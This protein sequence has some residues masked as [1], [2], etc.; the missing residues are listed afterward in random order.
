MTMRALITGGSRGLGRAMGVALARRGA[1]VAFT[2]A[3]RTADADAAR[4]AIAAAG[5]EPLVFQGSVADAAHAAATV[6]A[7]V[8]A[9]GGVDVLIHNAGVNQIL[10]VA[11]IEEQDWDTV[12]DVNVKG[13]FLFARACLKPMIRARRGAILFI[14]SFAS[15]R[16]V[17]SPVHYAAAKSALRGLT[18]ALA[19]EMGKYRIQV[20]LLAPGL[21]DA[22][23]TRSLPKHRID[24][25]LA[26]C[27]ARRI[28][29]VDELAEV[30]AWLVSE[31][32]S[33]M[34]GGKVVVDGGL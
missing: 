22:G 4:A 8:K 30:A 33:F 27:P 17:E 9:W 6:D 13:A 21:L 11:L 31:E 12:M 34:T 24:E 15:E 25:Y 16:I 32:N 28:G 14:G 7:L 23:V 10:P 20:N 2:Y 5:A 1:R 3:R 19:R 29:S 26:Q 18:E